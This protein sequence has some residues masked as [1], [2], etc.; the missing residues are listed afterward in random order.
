M[1]WRNPRLDNA[2]SSMVQTNKYRTLHA[3][4]TDIPCCI[5]DGVEW[6]VFIVEN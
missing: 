1:I 2:K 4:T 6:N 5:R 3:Y